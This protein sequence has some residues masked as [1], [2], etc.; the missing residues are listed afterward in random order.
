MVINIPTNQDLVYKQYLTILNS[1]LADSKLSPL[2]IDVL[3][4]LLFIHN[5]YISKGQ[6][7]A[8]KITF[9]KE[10]KSRIRQKIS[11]DLKSVFSVQSFNNTMMKLRN[12][13]FITDK[14]IKH[15][16]PFTKTGVTIIF[17]LNLKDEV[18]TT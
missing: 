4:S 18:N 13:G 12:K 16:V 10:T 14:T 9:H 6:E 3:A 15:K 2:E 1:I 11:Q 8:N 17:N 5:L 7:A